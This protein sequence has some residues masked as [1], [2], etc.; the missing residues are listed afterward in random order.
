MQRRAPWNFL[1][2]SCLTP[3]VPNSYNYAITNGMQ[4]ISVVSLRE[5]RE[6][7]HCLQEAI[8]AQRV[9]E[10]TTPEFEVNVLCV[11]SRTIQGT[12]G[13]S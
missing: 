1:R 2:P 3:R 6:A 10:Y 11:L 9:A 4:G 5:H 12:N 7:Q 8:A 13:A